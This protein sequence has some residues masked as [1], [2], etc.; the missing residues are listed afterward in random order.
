MADP[1]ILWF[2]QDLRLHDNAALTAAAESCRPVIAIYVLDDAACGRWAPGGS[3]RWW[4]HHSLQALGGSLS[5]IGSRLILRRGPTADVL[6]AIAAETGARALYCSRS[7]E[8]HAARMELAINAACSAAGIEVRRFSGALLMEPETLRNQSGAPFR[9]FTPFWRTVLSAGR[10]RVPVLAPRHLTQPKRW[11]VSERLD[12]WHLLPLKPDWAGGLRATWRPGEAG[13]AE[14]LSTLIDHALPHYATA[15]DCPDRPGTSMLSPH[16]HFGEISPR[17][18]WH[19]VDLAR[20]RDPGLDGGANSFLREIG[21]REF[22]CHLLHHWPTLPEVPFR[23]EFAAFPWEPD[24]TRARLMF[25]AWS[26]GQTGYP[27]VDAGMRQLWQTGWMHNRVRMITASF[28]T[29][30]LL[31]PWQTGQRWFWDTLVDADLAS[32]AASWQWVAGSGADA[33]PYFRIFNPVL[34]GQKFDCNGDYVRHFVPEIARLPT[35]LLHAPWTATD[36]Q[37]GRAGVR[38]GQTYP[39]PIV[40]HDDARRRAL[41]AFA[42]LKSGGTG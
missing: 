14:R 12:T 36:E 11:P 27:I 42:T 3:S 17:Q 19:A 26:R 10:P 5:A 22:S 20:E 40:G 32:N 35:K 38:L 31:V 15:R 39:R 2:R 30:H 41:A 18:C 24:G 29:K 1:V 8:P 16:L 23:P 9:V 13:A 6:L 4:L 21:W 28:L 34:Q 37:L 25:A 33:A 7:Y